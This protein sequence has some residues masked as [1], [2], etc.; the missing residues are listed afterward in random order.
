MRK[1]IKAEIKTLKWGP[2][3][4]SVSG[5]ASLGLSKQKWEMKKIVN[6]DIFGYTQKV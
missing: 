1:N 4:G 6:L 3:L 2:S 5:K